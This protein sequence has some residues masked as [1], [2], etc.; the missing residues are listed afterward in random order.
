MKLSRT[1]RPL[2]ALRIHRFSSSLQVC[3][4]V[5]LQFPSDKHLSC[6]RGGHSRN[7]SENASSLKK[8]G[9]F[10]EKCGGLGLHY[11]LKLS[12]GK[13][14]GRLTILMSHFV[15]F[16]HP[17]SKTRL[18]RVSNQRKAA[19]YAFSFRI[20]LAFPLSLTFLNKQTKMLNISYV[21]YF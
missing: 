9:G 13:V 18:K 3:P 16:E 7:F 2:S 12:S 6:Q 20:G 1:G 15:C 4:D 10:V 17:P 11:R 19:F 14:W 5:R 8:C 21:I